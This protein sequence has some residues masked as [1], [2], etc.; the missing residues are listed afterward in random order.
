MRCCHSLQLYAMLDSMGA[1]VCTIVDNSCEAA[2]T[3]IAPLSGLPNFAIIGVHTFVLVCNA[4]FAYAYLPIGKLVLIS[5]IPL[6]FPPVF[7]N[8]NNNTV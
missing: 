8:K 2:T 3:A 1:K 5:N 7:S 6:S 4:Y